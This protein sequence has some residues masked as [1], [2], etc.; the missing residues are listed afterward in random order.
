M[1]RVTKLLDE[2]VAKYLIIRPERKHLIE[3]LGNQSPEWVDACRTLIV[4]CES[5]RTMETNLKGAKPTEISG[6]YLSIDISNN[7][8]ENAKAED[9]RLLSCGSSIGKFDDAKRIA[10]SITTQ[11]INTRPQAGDYTKIAT[12]QRQTS[13]RKPTT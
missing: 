9:D 11:G 12:R 8:I 1:N 7:E 2:E 10:D 6:L 13:A 4:H 3:D 5:K